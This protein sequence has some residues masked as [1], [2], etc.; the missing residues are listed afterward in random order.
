MKED[1]KSFFLSCGATEQ[2]REEG[3]TTRQTTPNMYETL[4]GAKVAAAQFSRQ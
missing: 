2:A 1:S 4:N 3:A